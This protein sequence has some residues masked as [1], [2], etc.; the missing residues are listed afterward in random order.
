[1]LFS[2]IRSISG[3]VS[4]RRK[5][6]VGVV[7][8]FTIISAII[9]NRS[10]SIFYNQFNEILKNFSSDNLVWL[11]EMIDRRIFEIETITNNLAKSDHIL[12]TVEKKSEV[13]DC[14]KIYDLLGSFGVEYYF[15][16]GDGLGFLHSEKIKIN[17]PSEIAPI[18]FYNLLLGQQNTVSNIRRTQ[19]FYTIREKGLSRLYFINT[20]PIIDKS[21]KSVATLLTAT[22]INPNIYSQYDLNFIISNA[23]LGRYFNPRYIV[24]EDQEDTGLRARNYIIYDKYTNHLI[25]EVSHDGHK[26]EN[27]LGESLKRTVEKFGNITILLLILVFSFIFY[28]INYIMIRL[29]RLIRILKFINST[30]KIPTEDFDQFIKDYEDINSIDDF[31]QLNKEFEIFLKNHQLLFS[32]KNTLPVKLE[33]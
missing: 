2:A 24:S 27:S 30:G 33:E 13:R 5:V 29:R 16:L 11:H 19:N 17:N 26:I 6:V 23:E 21:G 3:V 20:S 32:E 4:F 14:H 9:Y 22:Y 31:G 10:Q 12:N 1:M 8:L 25:V 7:I 15:V 28:C 18:I